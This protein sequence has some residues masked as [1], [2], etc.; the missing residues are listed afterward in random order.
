MGTHLAVD[1]EPFDQ[2]LEVRQG[3]GA[4]LEHRAVLAGELVDLDQLWVVRCAGGLEQAAPQAAAQ[5]DECQQWLSGT[6]GIDCRGVAGDDPGLLQ[7]SN[8]LGNCWRGEMNSAGELVE[9]QPAVG[10]Q[11]LQ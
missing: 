2:P 11:L 5:L 10:L 9:G 6:R 7:A 3:R 4:D 8:P 1:T